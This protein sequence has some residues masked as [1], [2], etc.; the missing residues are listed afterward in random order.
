MKPNESILR[1]FEQVLDRH[2]ATLALWRDEAARRA[3]GLLT[4]YDGFVLSHYLVQDHPKSTYGIQRFK[5]IHEALSTALRWHFADSPRGFPSPVADGD[6]IDRAGKFLLFAADHFLLSNMHSMYGHGLIDVECNQTERRVRFVPRIRDPIPPWHSLVEGAISEQ[7]ERDGRAEVVNRIGKAALDL[8]FGLWDG[9]V[10]LRQPEQMLSSGLLVEAAALVAHDT[11][12]LPDSTTIDDFSL[13]TFR[14][15]WRTLELW[16]FCTSQIYLGLTIAGIDQS[17]CMPTQILSVERFVEAMGTMTGCAKSEILSIMNLLTFDP[18]RNKADVILQPLIRDERTVAWPVLAVR[19]SK[20]ERNLLKLMSRTPRL[21]ASAANLIG[22]RERQLLLDAGRFLAKRAGFQFKLNKSIVANGNEGEIDLLAY[23]SRAPEEILIVEAKAILGSDEVNEQVE[24]GR[25]MRRA[26]QQLQRC[27][28]II[29]ESSAE[30]LSRA[31]PFVDWSRVR[32][33]HRLILTPDTPPTSS[34][35]STTAAVS[36][37]TLQHA[38]RHR[39]LQTPS[40]ICAAARRRPQAASPPVL[41]VEYEVISVG[42]VTYE[43]PVGLLDEAD[44][45]GE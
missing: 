29:R 43:I 30:Y 31:Y 38:F 13:E 12:P 3:W 5:A 24:S 27:A 2:H 21:Q 17:L 44:E 34:F 39:D 26:D 6:L 18:A 25:V 11:L 36:F 32:T 15:F 42:D 35:G 14:A 23:T 19:L 37:L 16:S 10:I 1:G 40:R 41:R 22:G 45:D 9:H 4:A 28:E 8:D 33:V 20:P 7:I